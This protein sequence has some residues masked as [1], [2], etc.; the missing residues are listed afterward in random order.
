MKREAAEDVEEKRRE[1]AL[2]LLFRPSCR[3]LA[4]RR[5]ASGRRQ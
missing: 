4:G 2:L 5:E 3:A 1:Q